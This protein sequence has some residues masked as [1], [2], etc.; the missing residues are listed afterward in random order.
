M[1]GDQLSDGPGWYVVRTGP[2]QEQ[3]AISNLRSLSIEGFLP[4]VKVPR[5]NP[6]TGITTT[7]RGPMFPCYGFARFDAGRFLHRV[8]FTRGVRGIVSFGGTL[9]RLDDSIIELMRS[10]TE[11]NGLV[12][13]GAEL[14][15][16]DRVI[17]TRGQ[18]TNFTGVF[19]HGINGTDRVAI[20]LTA[21]RY[22]ARVVI[23]RKSV[24]KV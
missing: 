20:L 24:A 2:K 9:A 3:R 21:V 8:C 4:I 17:V 22:Q 5:V 12:R 13:L 19:E 11:E 16:G 6:F 15:S 23:D 1:N 10:R 18:L 14:R 7:V